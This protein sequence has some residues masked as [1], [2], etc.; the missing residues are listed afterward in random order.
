MTDRK[1]SREQRRLNLQ[2]VL[3]ATLCL[4]VI[5]SVVVVSVKRI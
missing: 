3:F 4:I 5:V 2:R 1:T